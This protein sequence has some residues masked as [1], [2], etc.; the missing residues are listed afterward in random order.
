MTNFRGREAELKE[1]MQLQQKTSASL[2]VFRGRRRIGKSR[3]AEEFSKQFPKSY[4]FSGL[5]PSKHPT[6]DAQRAEFRQQM[7]ELGIP[8]NDANDWSDLFRQVSKAAQQS[9]VLIVL[10]E[11]TWMG[12][13]DADFLGKLKITWDL[14][15]ADS[16]SK[17]NK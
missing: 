5:P 16:S 7:H 6:A 1:L 4:I 14:H 3:L 13:K 17:C 10:D 12:S 11:I 9:P 2:V 15:F 8:S